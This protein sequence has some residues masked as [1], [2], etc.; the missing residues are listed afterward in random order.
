MIGT[1]TQPM[2]AVVIASTGGEAAGDSPSITA[3]IAVITMLVVASAVAMLVRRVKLPYTIALVL[4]G[5]ALGSMRGLLPEQVLSLHLSQD[6]LLGILLPALLFE[7][8]FHLDLSDFRANMRAILLLALPGVAL[9]IFLAGAGFSVVLPWFDMRVGFLV[10]CLVGSMLAATDPVSVISIFKELGAPRRLALI[11]EGE[12]LL[13]DGVAVVAFWALA[14]AAGISPGVG[15]VDAV[16][17]LRF[18][19]LEM[20]G[21]VAIGLAVGVLVSWILSL[22]DDHLIEITLTTIVAYGS[23][24]VASKVGASGVIAVVVAGM[25]CGNIGAARGMSAATRVAVIS[26]WEYVAFAVNSIVF[27][28]I[29]AEIELHRLVSVLPAAAVL[30]AI[31]TIVRAVVIWSIAPVVARR[32]GAFGAGWKE[33]LTWGGLRGGISMVLALWLARQHGFALGEKIRDLVFA[34]VLIVLLLQGP[35]IGLLLKRFGLVFACEERDRASR[36]RVR[37]KAVK[38]AL[39]ELDRRYSDHAISNAAYEAVREQYAA[40]QGEIEEELQALAP[41][42]EALDRE[43][44]SVQHSLALVEKD[45]IRSAFASGRIPEEAMRELLSKLDAKGD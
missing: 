14:A 37:M 7:A 38:T 23:Y 22:V 31:L 42:A 26:F 24:L 28:L 12:S 11:M 41:E 45:A 27:L 21:G 36:L 25:T 9:G 34:V 40:Q 16:W 1:W 3:E 39:K 32:E 43:I 8:A 33:V 13:N 2:L 18:L 44:E 29:G 30:F 35:T 15:Q 17:V 10:A 19:L 4:A 20:V 6:L 5:L